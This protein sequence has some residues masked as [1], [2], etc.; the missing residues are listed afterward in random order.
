MTRKP[1]SPSATPP[2]ESKPTTPA[3]SAKPLSQRNFISSGRALSVL[4]PSDLAASLQWVRR[5]TSHTEPSP[6]TTSTSADAKAGG[7]VAG[8]AAS[9]SRNWVLSFEPRNVKSK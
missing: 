2:A 1:G 3:D 4:A 9:I 5:F 7:S 8:F 6:M